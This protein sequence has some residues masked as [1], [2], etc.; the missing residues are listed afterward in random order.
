M[1]DPKRLR[2]LKEADD[3]QARVI[4]SDIEGGMRLIGTA[5]LE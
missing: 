1:I 2:R 5:G 3:A 4:A